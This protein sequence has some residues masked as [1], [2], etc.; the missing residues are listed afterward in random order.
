MTWHTEVVAPGEFQAFL[1][2]LQRT[3][4]T[5]TSSCP[6]SGGYSVTYVTPGN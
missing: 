5:I 6:C 4:G 2:A 1:G 3:G